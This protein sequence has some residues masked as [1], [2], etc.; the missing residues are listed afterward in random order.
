MFILEFFLCFVLA[1][2][3]SFF[4]TT[5]IIHVNEYVLILKKLFNNICILYENATFKSDNFG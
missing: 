3:G 2:G 1:G 4:D 5:K